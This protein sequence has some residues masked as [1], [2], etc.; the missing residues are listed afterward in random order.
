MHIAVFGLRNAYDG[1]C[2]LTRRAVQERIRACRDAQVP[3]VN[4]GI[5]IAQCHGIEV[6]PGSVAG[7]RT[8]L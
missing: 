7:R 1:G 8:N 5:A 3:I 4:Y 2:M 6:S